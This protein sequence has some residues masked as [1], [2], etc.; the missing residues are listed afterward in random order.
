MVPGTELSCDYEGTEIHMLGLFID[1][2]NPALRDFLT[3][4]R[5]TRDERNQA[6][7]KRFEAGGFA[8]APPKT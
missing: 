8:L 7:L 5:K 3:N 4:M 6:M 1:S 2:E